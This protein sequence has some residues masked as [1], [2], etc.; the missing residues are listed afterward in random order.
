MK[1]RTRYADLFDASES[2]RIAVIGTTAMQDQLVA[3]VVETDQK[4]SRYMRRLAKSY[5]HVVEVDRSPGPIA[6]TITV[7]VTSGKHLAELRKSG[8]L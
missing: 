1:G 8:E 2:E 7:R 4:A 5:P 6:N 3:F